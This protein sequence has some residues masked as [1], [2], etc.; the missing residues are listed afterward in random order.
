MGNARKRKSDAIDPGMGPCPEPRCHGKIRY[1]TR[2][3]A[4]R[5][6]RQLWPG[7]HFSEY[8]CGEFWHFGH[9]PPAIVAGR[10]SRDGFAEVVQRNRRA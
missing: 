9:L 10:L 3:A 7:N 2:T 1:L 5:R 4:R 6:S 8:R